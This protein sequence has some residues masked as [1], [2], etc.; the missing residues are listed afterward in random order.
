MTQIALT[1][2][3]LD[4]SDTR[5]QHVYVHTLGHADPDNVAAI[6]RGMYNVSTGSS[7]TTQSPAGSALNQRL[8]NG[9]TS[10]FSSS[11]GTNG[12]NSSGRSTGGLR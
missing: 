6:L 7:S 9:T 12:S 10:D 2:G 11:P 8:L 3:R 5:K 4:A 1:V